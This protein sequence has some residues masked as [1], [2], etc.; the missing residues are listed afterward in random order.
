LSNMEFVQFNLYPVGPEGGPLPHNDDLLYLAMGGTLLNSRNERF[1]LN[2][3]LLT[4]ELRP[5]LAPP[6][7]LV[8]EVH[9]QES[10]GLGPVHSPGGEI[11]A[12]S[13]GLPYLR[14]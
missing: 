11:A 4:A 6:A 10:L 3:E 9:P 1:L 12:D 14:S 13:N 2:A 8:A 5:E 7:N